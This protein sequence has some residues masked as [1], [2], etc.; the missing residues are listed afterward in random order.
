M[1]IYVSAV[2]EAEVAFA[3]AE[4]PGGILDPKVEKAPDQLWADRR[5]LEVIEFHPTVAKVADPG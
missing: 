2:S 3:Q 5:M 4:Q 1:R